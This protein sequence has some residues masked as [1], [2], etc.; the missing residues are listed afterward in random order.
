M[1]HRLHSICAEL[2]ATRG[3]LVLSLCGSE[4]LFLHGCSVR[5]LAVGQKVC[6]LLQQ[7]IMGAEQVGNL[8]MQTMR[9]ADVPHADL[10]LY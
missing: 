10:L 6:E 2:A 1:A 7:I 4:A 9:S 3:V 5:S 8:R